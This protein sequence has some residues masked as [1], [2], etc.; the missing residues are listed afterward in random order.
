MVTYLSAP[1]LAYGRA[2]R[3]RVYLTHLEKRDFKLFQLRAKKKL[4][5][6]AT[7]NQEK[8]ICWQDLSPK[9]VRHA[10]IDNKIS[11]VIGGDSVSGGIK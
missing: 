5:F 2:G 4:K 7:F 6:T 3:D 9:A 8:P 11:D 10:R 1:K